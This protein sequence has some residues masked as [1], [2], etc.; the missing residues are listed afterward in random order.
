MKLHHI[1]A[2]VLLL[3]LAGTSLLVGVA[4]VSLSQILAGD[5][6]SLNILLVSRLPRL[7]A[8][9][10]AGAGLSIAGLIMQQIVQNRFAA[11]STTGTVDWAMFGY[12]IALI[13]FSD[14]SSWVHLITIFAFSVL[15][16][17]IFVRFLQRLKFKNTVLVP[18]IGIM[19]GNVVSSMTT[20]VAYKYDLVQTLGSWTVANFASVLRGNYE[21]LYL[22]LPVSLLAYAYANRFSAASVGESFA[23]NIG[24]NYQRIVLIGVILV[25]VLSSS[26]VMI[27]GMIPFLGLIVP[28][29]VS[30]FIGD[31]MRRNLPWT[32]YAGV[33]LVLTCDIVGR[34]IIFPYEIPISMIISILGG[35]V[36]IYLVLRDKANA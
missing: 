36:F 27:V 22:A 30:I 14:M 24:L 7:L 17:V 10:L 18:L 33:I 35:S 34:L 31:N 19:Y 15:G 21:F 3:I 25:A 26:V 12:I 32:A 4:N 6:H 13:F 28:N 20:F 1:L 9:I 5:S 29:L 23:K 8:I 16:T 2:F 11:P